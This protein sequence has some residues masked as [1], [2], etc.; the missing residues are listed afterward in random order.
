L[1]IT[2]GVHTA[3]DALKALM[4]GGNI[5]MMTSAI[6]ESGFDHFGK[7]LK[8]MEHWLDEHEYDSI[9][10][11]HGSMSQRSVGEP[12]AYERANYLK[13]LTSYVPRV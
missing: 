13:V 1:A 3:T 2:G 7:I 10:L 9:K 11:L 8:E 5:A 12:A 6:L 4:V